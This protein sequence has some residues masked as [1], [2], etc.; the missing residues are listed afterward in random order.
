MSCPISTRRG[1]IAYDEEEEHVLHDACGVIGVV[2]SNLQE[3]EVSSLLCLGMV[4]L[5]HRLVRIPVRITLLS[6]GFLCAK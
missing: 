5:Q 4:A 6:L 1:T 3:T 2:S